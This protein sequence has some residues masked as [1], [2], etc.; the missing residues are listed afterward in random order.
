MKILKSI[1]NF[2]C[3]WGEGWVEYRRSQA[4]RHSGWL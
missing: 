2:M 1:W 3:A 4:V